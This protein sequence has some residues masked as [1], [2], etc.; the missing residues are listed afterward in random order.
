MLND[1]LR[2]LLP[3]LL[4]LRS[5]RR[6]RHRQNRLRFGAQPRRP[7]A[8]SI[9][10]S[11]HRQN[12]LRFGAAVMLVPLAL[13]LLPAAA[14]ADPTPPD[15][16]PIVI[17][18]Q[19]I[20]IY[21]RQ[22]GGGT[23]LGYE[24]R[25]PFSSALQALG[26][27]PVAGYPISVPF[28]GTDGCTYQAFQVL[29]LQACPGLDVRLANTF[30]IL[31]EA[32]ADG[33]LQQ[34]GIGPGEDDHSRSFEE[35]VQIRLTW[36]T[37]PAIAERYLTQCG[38]G[39]AMVA[40]QRCGLPM[41]H[42]AGFGP[43]IAQRFQRI[44]F[45]RWLVDGPGGIKVGDVTAVLGGDLLKLAGVLS[46]TI[47]QPQALGQAVPLLTVSLSGQPGQGA[48][49][50]LLPTQPAATPAATPASTTTPAGAAVTRTTPLSFGFQADLFSPQLR[51]QAIALIRTAGF[52]WV[53]QQVIW[54][55]YELS[56]SECSANAANCVQ[57]TINGRL[58]AFR[59]DRLGFLDAVVND[60]NAAGLSLLLSVVRAPA[61]Y[62]APGGNAPADA[63]M[64]GDFVQL[65][66]SR[67][68][69]KVQAIEP[70]NEQ[71]LSWEWGGARLWPNAPAAPPQG[72]VDFVALQR[73]AY[74]GIKA[75]DPRIIVVLPALTPT[76]V[77]ECWVNEQART[78][79]F[80]LDAVR[81][82][83]DDRLYLD[84]LFQVNGGE[85]KRYY[86][87]LGVHPS[88]YNNP[89]DDWI[90]RQ[91]V[92][93]TSFKG[94]PSF[95]VRRYQQLHEVQLKYG[96]SKPMWFTEVGWDST[97]MP[98]AGYEYGQ[99]NSEAARGR[100]LARLL[101][102]VSNEAPYVTNIFIWNLNF[103][104]VV[105]E[106]DEKYGFGVVDSSGNP[107]PAY[108]CVADFVRSGSRITRPECRG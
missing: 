12:R 45:Q 33:R 31:Q 65:L 37:D 78:Q 47:V 40:V 1:T 77:G 108:T 82:A 95:Y 70:W 64:L 80:C 99:D 7:I 6:S 68:A 14:T 19:T 20:G 97:R 93:S 34:L 28:A 24:V 87:V 100:Y 66:A 8:G 21:Y 25:E 35:A 81:T 63:Q 30:Q 96:D 91:T 11:R 38:D 89:P 51:P 16:E 44:A 49:G 76:G 36:L 62:A 79:A 59:K 67:Y 42:P 3:S 52:S 61:F 103:R 56:A 71:N 13:A 75:A 5:I 74:T 10:N 106:T 43:F 55:D 26:G 102:Q 69:G 18:G 48:G 4:W 101:E 46:G 73:A 90:D 104:Q 98:V 107:L 88:G 15:Q 94:H 2:R 32:G 86:D 23:G 9:E 27:P 85:I 29:L 72:V 60:V 57:V 92:P 53:K 83:I 58:K 105:P 84:F 22:T 41:N 17:D 54:S 50:S 39:D